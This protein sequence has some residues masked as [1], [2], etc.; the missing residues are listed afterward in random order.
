MTTAKKRNTNLE[1]LRII[2][3]FFIIAH[4][5]AVHGMGGV[6]FV[7]S[8]PNNYLIYFAGILG[9]IGVVVFIL[10]SSYFMVNSRFTFRKFMFIAG[11]VWFYSL[12]F[13]ILFLTV[14]TPAIELNISNIGIHLLAISHSAY[15]FVTDYI[16]LMVLSP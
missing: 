14:L 3:M 7:A 15:W 12:L 5:F 6:N 13:L 9:K 10:I 16:I 1:I 4:H 8:N 11:E 2:A